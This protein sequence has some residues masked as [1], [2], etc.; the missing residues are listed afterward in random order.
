[1]QNCPVVNLIN[2]SKQMLEKMDAAILR[3]D[4]LAAGRYGESAISLQAEADRIAPKS[5]LG[6]GHKLESVVDALES[7]PEWPLAEAVA[8]RLTPIA[9][10][11]LKSRIELTDLMFLRNVY[12]ASSALWPVVNKALR[13]VLS[14]ASRPRPVGVA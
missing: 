7:E 12:G 1:M 8:A 2:R 13:E 5:L 11:L 3:G 6:A 4:K 14:A 10:R 9:R